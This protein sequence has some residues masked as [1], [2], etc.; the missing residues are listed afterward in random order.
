ML[1]KYYIDGKDH[2]D[3]NLYRFGMEDCSADYSW[4]PA[5]RDHYQI[6]FVFQGKGEFNILGNKYQITKNQ[7][8]LIP[9]NTVVSYKADHENPWS[10]CW[11]GFNGVKAEYY[12]HKMGLS[13]QNPVF[14]CIED[15]KLPSIVKNML[16]AKDIKK[17]RELNLLANLYMFLYELI[18]KT[19]KEELTLD[20][21]SRKEEYLQ[22]SID[23]IA[24][25]YSM[26]ITIH[27]I[28]NHIGI[29]RSY[30]F[31]IFKEY[32][33]T[34]PSEYLI[35]YRINVAIELL[36]NKSLSIGEIS[37]S[38]GYNDQFVFSK[39]FKKINSLSPE[40]YRLK[41]FQ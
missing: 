27:E 34:S 25:N 15:T 17:G 38:V 40:K 6:H 12:V 41:F 37:R 19:D 13:Y 9:P 5:L 26:P 21:H 18:E 2:T 32:L 36:K 1:D 20:L 11:V 7:G 23:F 39:T 4:G 22:T 31:L 14:I 16:Q 35:K 10:Y 28:A 33:S 24:K 29:D 8:F 30:L 3:L